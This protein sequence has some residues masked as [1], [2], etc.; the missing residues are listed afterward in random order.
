MVNFN[1]KKT[2]WSTGSHHAG[3]REYTF[4][5]LLEALEIILFNTHIQVNG[6]IFKQILGITMGGNAS[7][8]IDHLYLSWCECCYTTKV[9]KINY[10]LAKSL[11]YICRYLDDICALNL[12]HFG[13]IVKDMYNN[14][15]LL[16]GSAYSY[17]QDTL[18]I[19][20]SLHQLNTNT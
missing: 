2:L 10:E 16:P 3:Y 13:Y 8:F 5:K 14:I 7:P 1:Q 19:F 9:V 17:K 11:S 20:K 12:K 6:S 15:L 18:G 4:D